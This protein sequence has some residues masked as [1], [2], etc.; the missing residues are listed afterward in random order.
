M[1]LAPSNSGQGTIQRRRRRDVAQ[2]PNSVADRAARHLAEQE[3]TLRGM[4]RAGAAVLGALTV[5]SAIARGP[6]HALGVYG[7]GV[8]LHVGHLAALRSGRTRLVAQSHC[9]LYLEIGRAH[10]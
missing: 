7:V 3:R 4:L 5:W 9:I 1:C 6:S 10:V 2:L 8:A